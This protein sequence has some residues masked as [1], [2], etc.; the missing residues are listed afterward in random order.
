MKYSYVM[1]IGEAE[2]FSERLKRELQALEAANVHAILETEPI[3]EEVLRGL[4]TAMNCVDDMEEWL[5]IF[6]VKLRHMR[7]DLQSIE[8]R[9]NKL[10]MQSVNNKSLIEE[11]DKLLERLNIPAEYSAIL[12]GGSFDEASMVK[13]IE[14]CEWL[15]GALCGLV[16]PNLDPIFA[17]MRAVK[18]KKGELE[19]LKVS[20]VQRASEFLTNYFAS[21]VDFMLNDKSYFSRV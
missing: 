20:F 13:A 15:S 12:T 7:E 17:N 16:V 18:E 14:A 8:T 4:D 10:E 3:V 5:G 6:N 11:L 21:L 9:N 2:A 1:G 19:I